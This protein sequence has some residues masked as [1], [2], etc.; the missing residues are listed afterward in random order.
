MY[1]YLNQ[2][3]VEIV[4]LWDRYYNLTDRLL[5]ETL[6]R[7]RPLNPEKEEADLIRSSYENVFEELRKKSLHE[8]LEIPSDFKLSSKNDSSMN[9]TSI[10]LQFETSMN[11]SMIKLLDKKS[12]WYQRN[13][14]NFYLFFNRKKRHFT[15]RFEEE[16]RKCPEFLQFFS[17]CSLLVGK[18]FNSLFEAFSPR[19]IL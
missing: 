4:R 12:D 10:R 6:S 18:L 11:R 2:S 7:D 14:R 8:L 19:Q 17:I 15:R 16:K 5:N 1:V 9:W 3:D 13:L